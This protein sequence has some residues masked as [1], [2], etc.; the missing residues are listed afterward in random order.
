MLKHLELEKKKEEFA[1][2]HSDYKPPESFTSY[3]IE[4]W[5]NWYRYQSF[6]Y[7]GKNREAFE[8]EINRLEV[9]NPAFSKSYEM[10]QKKFGLN[11]FEYKTF[12][13][14]ELEYHETVQFKVNRVKTLLES[15]IRRTRQSQEPKSEQ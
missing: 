9:T 12:R 10:F 6:L 2:T 13:E 15:F 1:R 8:E 11:G 5:E 14:L 7:T 4:L 3:S